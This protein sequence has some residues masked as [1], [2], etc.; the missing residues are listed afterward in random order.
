MRLLLDVTR[1]LARLYRASTSGID[2]VEDA[3]IRR[4]AT[5]EGAAPWKEVH[6]VVLT[7]ARQFSLT[8]RRLHRI[9]ARRSHLDRPAGLS[10]FDEVKNWL[11]QP[12]T[13]SEG[14]GV[15]RFDVSG[16]TST[17]L[18][19]YWQILKASARSPGVLERLARGNDM[20]TAYLHVSHILLER[21]HLFRWLGSP[22][23][24]AAFFLHDTIPV[25]YPEFCGERSAEENLARIR[26]I[27][28]RGDLIL[29]NSRTT[30]DA[31]ARLQEGEGLRQ[32]PVRTIP[33]S[34]TIPLPEGA[35]SP[36]P[37]C[38]AR[39]YF[40]CAGTIEGRKNIGFLLNVWRSMVAD[41]VPEDVPRLVIAGE[42]GWAC[43]EVLA[44]LDRT[45]GLSRHVAE[46]RGVSDAEMVAL[47]RGARA[48]LAPSLAEGFGL[49]P[50]EAMTLGTKVIASDIPAHRETLTD[51]ATLLDPTDGPG[52]RREILSRAS[53]MQI[54][55]EEP[56]PSHSGPSW[57]DHADA[58]LGEVRKMLAND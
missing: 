8:S 37:P 46:V 31:L 28:A 14:F 40:L 26:A 29:V 52:W 4:L 19:A 7:P 21:A 36:S 11:E 10:V 48:V 27:S 15:R 17:R 51:R 30:E 18:P 32:P 24:K 50:V 5:P 3:L 22:S 58:V 39:P 1:T 42:R 43:Q 33:L 23:T 54:R 45:R 13:P 35:L 47:V 25:E 12:T 6:Y 55:N 53:S 57:A 34:G 20:P 9:L 49:V 41:L 56:A 38:P 44:T 2:R 16:R